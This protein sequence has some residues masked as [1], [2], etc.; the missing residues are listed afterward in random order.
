M[1]LTREDVW[2]RRL[3][4]WGRQYER[5]NL[6]TLEELGKSSARGERLKEHQRA[7]SYSWHIQYGV[8]FL[9]D[10]I[11]G[12][13]ILQS[14]ATLD[15]LDEDGNPL[16]D[17][18]TRAEVDDWLESLWRISALQHR[19][20]EVAR[21]VLVAGDL[22]AELK[23]RP[24]ADDDEPAVRIDLWERDVFDLEYDPDDWQRLSKVTLELDDEVKVYE[25]RTYTFSDGVEREEATELIFDREEW[26]GQTEDNPATPISTRRLGLPFLPF[27]HIHGENESLRSAFGRSLISDQLMETADRYNA[28]RQLEFLAVRYNSFATMVVVGDQALLKFDEEGTVVHKDVGDFIPFPGGTDVKAVQLPTD[29]DLIQ[30]QADALEVEMYKLMGLQ[31]IDAEDIRSFGGVSGYALEILNRETDGTFRRIV[32]NLSEGYKAT[33]EVAFHVDAISRQRTV[34]EEN[35]EIRFWDIDVEEVWPDRLVRVDFGTAYIVDEVAIRDDFVA[36]IIS[37]QEALRKKGYKRDEI[38]KILDEL[39]VGTDQGEQR[40]SLEQGTRFSTERG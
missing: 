14:E 13:M 19:N 6:A 29:V 32:E 11:T 39:G 17:D 15:E 7:H 40:Q 34:D 38:A 37:V 26:E 22:L 3:Y 24:Q 36:G 16:P 31:K 5:L 2:K 35:G 9:A 8:D 18:Q 23:P 1:P 30:D 4:Y 20:Q 28:L 10:Q 12:G 21:E 27:V 25:M 33:I